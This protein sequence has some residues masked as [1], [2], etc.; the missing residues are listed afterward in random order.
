MDTTNSSNI[1]VIDCSLLDPSDYYEALSCNLSCNLSSCDYNDSSDYWEALS[2]NQS[3]CPS[4]FCELGPQQERLFE[5][6]QSCVFILVFLLG[7]AGN[8]LVIATF[9]FYRRLRLRSLTDVFLL[10]LALADLLLLLTLPLKGAASYLGWVFSAPLCKATRA[11]HAL[12]TC[13]GLLLLACVSVDR[14]LAV[15][16]AQD[17]L[18]HRRRILAAGKMAAAAVWLTAALVSSP[19]ALYSGVY[20]AGGV[21]YCV[22]RLSGRAKMATDAATI[23]VFCLSLAVMAICYGAV[24]RVLWRGRGQAGGRGQHGGRG[25]TKGRGRRWRHQRTLVLMLCLVAAFVLFQLPYTLVLSHKMAAKMAGGSCLLRVLE[26]VTCTLA[27]AR[28]CLNPVLYA[29]VGVRFR[30]DVRKLLRDRGCPWRPP[31]GSRT[32]SAS[33]SASISASSPAL[34]MLSTSPTD[35]SWELHL[36]GGKAAGS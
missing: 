24:A 8:L 35:R 1:T 34:S 16:R 31:P 2:C 9:S 10:H 27:Y 29:L 33:N 23:A 6:F 30:R 3:S 25:Q 13:S 5:A 15:A 14:Y 17:A 36:L 7:V 22:V 28:C 12:N 32:G 21:A 4:D 19:E 26:Y 20:E 11:C 18:R